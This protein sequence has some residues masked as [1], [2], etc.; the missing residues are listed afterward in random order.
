MCSTFDCVRCIIVIQLTIIYY[1]AFVA[2]Y[3]ITDHS[4]DL[5]NLNHSIDFLNMP[6]QTWS[7]KQKEIQSTVLSSTIFPTCLIASD[8]S[9]ILTLSALHEPTTLLPDFVN[10]FLS[11]SILSVVDDSSSTGV[12]TSSFQFEKIPFQNLKSSSPSVHHNFSHNLELP[13]LPTMES[14]CEDMITPSIPAD[15]SQANNEIMTMLSAISNQM[16]SN[17]Q[18]FRDQLICM[19]EKL[20][21]QL[22]RA[23]QDHESFK[24]EIHAKILAL[25]ISS[26]MHLSSTPSPAM[27]ISS[28]VIPPIVTSVTVLQNPSFISNS[29][30]QLDFQAQ[31][32][33]MLN[34]TFSKL[35]TTLVEN[36]SQESKL[37]W[38]K[39]LGDS[40]KFRFWY[41]AIMAQVSLPP[42][43]E[44]YDSVANTVV[45]STQNTILNGKLYAK[46][47]VSLESQAFQHMMSRKHLRANGILLLKE[48]QQMYKPRN[49]PKIIVAKT[50]EIGRK[51]SILYMKM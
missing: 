2:T 18:N 50:G 49:V 51:L 25:G 5:S 20:A 24:Q 13:D 33:V 47:L 7:M 9:N 45:S 39:F 37:E 23:V 34:D 31:M 15:T 28:S 29:T 40:K 12:A 27:N 14:D 38:P 6:V 36:K 26:N 44:L 22:Q 30:S 1:Y 11:Q 8:S 42:W 10:R 35:S 32:M 43:A 41:L 19:D 48:L 16:M 21:Q 3:I 17:L 4:I 46:L